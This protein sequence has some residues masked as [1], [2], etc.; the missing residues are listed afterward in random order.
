M[1]FERKSSEVAKL[2]MTPPVLSRFCGSSLPTTWLVS[3][4]DVLPTNLGRPG[5]LVAKELCMTTAMRVAN[6]FAKEVY[7]TYP[8]PFS[9]QNNP[10]SRTLW[11]D[12]R[13]L[14]SCDLNI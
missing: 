9:A 5:G 2:Y 11:E 8:V 10:W 13:K 12:E 3:F 7:E 1:N 14:D 4:T 6:A